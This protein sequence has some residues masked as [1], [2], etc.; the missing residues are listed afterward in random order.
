MKLKV[1]V[2]PTC[3]VLRT[4]SSKRSNKSFPGLTDGLLDPCDSAATPKRV[5][6]L[7]TNSTHFGS[8]RG[9]HH[10]KS[11]LQAKARYCRRGKVCQHPLCGDSCP[12]PKELS[13]AMPIN[14]AHLTSSLY[15]SAAAQARCCGDVWLEEP[16]AMEL[17]AMEASAADKATVEP[18]L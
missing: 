3:K 15:D 12:F 11:S 2:S 14:P 13:C 5:S 8:K 17:K 1:K 6:S 4:E 18:S 16:S 9:G 7:N 10:Q